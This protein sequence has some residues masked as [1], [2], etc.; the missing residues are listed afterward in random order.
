MA[1]MTPATAFEIPPEDEAAV[2]DPEGPVEVDVDVVAQTPVEFPQA[3][4][5]DA[6]SP[7]A[8]LFISVTK[9][10]HGITVSFWPN[11]G[12]AVSGFW[13]AVPLEKRKRTEISSLEGYEA[14]ETVAFVTSSKVMEE[15]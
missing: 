5:Q 3:L 9:V 14:L 15:A 12:Y 8:N 13:A 1:P 4:H 7:I 11:N 2:G 6:W 10:F